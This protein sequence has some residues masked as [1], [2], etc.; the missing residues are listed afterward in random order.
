[1]NEWQ[2]GIAKI[3][4]PTPFPVGDVNVF[5]IKGERLTMVDAGTNTDEA[6]CAFVKQLNDLH[7]TERDIEQ[8]IITHHHP[9]HVGLLARFPESVPV[10]GHPL[11][12]RWL[13]VTESFILENEEFF[14]R[15]LAEFGV[16]ETFLALKGAFRKMTKYSSNRLL[17]GHLVEGDV[18]PGLHGWKVIETPGH[19]SSHIGLLR[20]S[21]GVYIGGD[22]LLPDISPNPMLEP[23]L[24]PEQARPQPQLQLNAS[25]KKLAR[26]SI[27]RVHPGHGDDI[28]E[29]GPLIEKRLSRQHERAMQVKKWLEQEAMTVF[30][31]CQRLFSHIYERELILTLSE[32]AAQIDYLL[33]RQEITMINEEFPYRYKAN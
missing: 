11:N 21:D 32:T 8:I 16:P 24:A 3:T 13:T 6:W 31:I 10:Y 12:Q 18:P 23:P 29:V 19:A 9:D 5:L 7:L 20:E 30:E 27:Q 22:Q 4:L 15:T 17:T 25:L 28:T 26:L 1:M 2:N 33:S 14:V